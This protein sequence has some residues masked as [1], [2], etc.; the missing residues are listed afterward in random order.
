MKFPK[1]FEP[2]RIGKITIWAARQRGIEQRQRGKSA[3][4]KHPH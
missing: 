1:L 2:M 4:A 3:A